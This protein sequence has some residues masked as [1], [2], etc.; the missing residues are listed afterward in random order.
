MKIHIEFEVNSLTETT[1][2]ALRML[3]LSDGTSPEPVAP[4]G[5]DVEALERGMEQCREL[6]EMWSEGWKEDHGPTDERDRGSRL[7]EMVRPPHGSD[8]MLYLRH[9]GQSQRNMMEAG[10]TREVARNIIAV[11]T[12][13]RLWNTK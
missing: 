12:A 13:L 11:G 8:L 6:V 2:H 5:P 1:L 9:E 7:Q 10:A 3:F 4:E